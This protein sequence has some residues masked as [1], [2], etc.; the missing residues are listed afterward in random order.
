[1]NY[2]KKSPT[3]SVE[4][5]AEQTLTIGP[6]P[7]AFFG[8]WLGIHILKHKRLNWEINRKADRA[9][10]WSPS[11]HKTAHTHAKLFPFAPP[12]FP[13][14]PKTT[15]LIIHLLPSTTRYT[16]QKLPHHIE[17]TSTKPMHTPTHIH[18][19]HTHTNTSPRTRPF[20]L[21]CVV[22]ISEQTTTVYAHHPE[23]HLVKPRER[24]TV[25]APEKTPRRQGCCCGYDAKLRLTDP[26]Q[27]LPVV[28]CG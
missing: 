16:F 25:I 1:M 17:T 7:V 24:E 5:A 18:T 2:E 12:K 10:E 3:K 21:E 22:S 15:N 14:P 6:L 19:R 28:P 11:A 13:S 4:C 20:S 27:Q 9:I 8:G 23:A 26:Q